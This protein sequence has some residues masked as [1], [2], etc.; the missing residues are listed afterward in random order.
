MAHHLS[1]I[2]NKLQHMGS[3]VAD[4][5][6][7]NKQAYPRYQIVNYGKLSTENFQSFFQDLILIIERQQDI[8]AAPA[9]DRDSMLHELAAEL[10][11][12]RESAEPG[13]RLATSQSESVIGAQNVNMKALLQ[14]IRE[15]S[16]ALQKQDLREV[17]G[18]LLQSYQTGPLRQDTSRASKDLRKFRSKSQ[19]IL[20]DA[21]DAH[22]TSF[23][24][25]C[26]DTNT[27][28]ISRNPPLYSFRQR[29]EPS[30]SRYGWTSDDEDE[31]LPE[32]KTSSTV[33][34]L[35][36]PANARQS[37]VYSSNFARTLHRS[38]LQF[39]DQTAQW[40]QPPPPP[41]R[42]SSTAPRTDEVVMLTR[43]LEQL[44]MRLKVLQAT[45]LQ[46]TGQN[47]QQTGQNFQ[48]TGQNFQQ[49]GQN[50]QQTDQNF[51]QT[52]QNFQQTGQNFQQTGQNFQQTGQNFQ[53]TGRNFQ[54][55]GQNLSHFN[56]N[57][58][59]MLTVPAPQLPIFHGDP[60]KDTLSADTFARRFMTLSGVYGSPQ[61]LEFYLETCLSG[62]ALNWY[63]FFATTNP[64]RSVEMTLSALQNQFGSVLTPL[65][66][67]RR[68]E[69]RTQ[70]PAEP[71]QAYFNEKLRLLAAWNNSVQHADACEFLW[72]GLL[73]QLCRDTRHVPRS[74]VQEFTKECFRIE[75]ENKRIADKA[76]VSFPSA[77]TLNAIATN[78]D[79]SLL[80]SITELL[81]CHIDKSTSGNFRNSPH[82]SRPTSH[83]PSRSPSRE[84]TASSRPSR[85]DGY[86]RRSS[87]DRDDSRRHYED[88]RS[89]RDR[90]DSR[91]RYEDR[92]SSRDRNDSSRRYG[93]RRSSRDRDDSC[94]RY[95][96]RRSSRDRNDS[97]RRYGDRRSSRDRDDSRRRYEDRRSSRDR[98]GS[99]HRYE[100]RS[101]SRDRNRSRDAE[102]DNAQQP[103]RRQENQPK[104][105]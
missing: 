4:F 96:D 101:G 38:Q 43:Q 53:Q 54:Q 44:Q 32:P 63:K 7:S 11:I 8:N 69:A 9:R 17:L 94:R 21:I 68:M 26:T 14:K 67:F 39:V 60:S 20:Q 34:S 13:F 72:D 19:E 15:L 102:R 12:R 37:P 51:Q 66:L 18:A 90:D 91:R 22:P 52:G 70:Q 46:R 95:E 64:Q 6:L 100:D 83:P 49:T 92:R 86:E 33:T 57:F 58:Q 82:P 89:S 27:G 45:N 10:K 1:P 3:L 35:A 104:N 97:S 50:F 59:T 23:L 93:D 47:F 24:D 105:Y 65:Q 87:R 85:R 61:Q 75:A 79:Q 16:S 81:H 74:S 30:R 55:T 77:A 40:P 2:H 36:A 98:N 103:D 29:T 56:Q 71:L 62:N 84:R 88:H 80:T 31:T 25:S 5:M 99:R 41:P 76:K 42:Q 48:Q 78:Q 73:P 28:A